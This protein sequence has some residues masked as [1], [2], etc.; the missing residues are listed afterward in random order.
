MVNVVMVLFSLLVPLVHL[1]IT[2]GPWMRRNVLR[3]FLI[4]ALALS[5]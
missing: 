4:Y 3:V 5:H 1:T 2:K